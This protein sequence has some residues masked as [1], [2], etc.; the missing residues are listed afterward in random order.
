M[1]MM[2]TCH[3]DTVLSRSL[4]WHQPHFKDTEAQSHLC[5]PKDSKATP[6]HES[7]IKI[8]LPPSELT[9]QQFGFHVENSLRLKSSKQR[10]RE[11]KRWT[12]RHHRRWHGQRPS[13][14][15]AQ[16][17]AQPDNLYHQ[18][19]P[20]SCCCRHKAECR[21]AWAAVD[22]G[23]K[24]SPVNPDPPPKL[25]GPGK[26]EL[27][28]PQPGATN[29]RVLSPKL[30]LRGWVRLVCW[31]FF[32]LNLCCVGPNSVWTSSLNEKRVMNILKT[33]LGHHPAMHVR[34]CFGFRPFP[35]PLLILLMCLIICR[36]VNVQV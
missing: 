8:S 14:A 30:S 26:V 29:R 28:P 17:L 19:K 10:L 2:M 20:V 5:H 36:Y 7:N 22:A 3:V 13:K 15:L 23:E 33:H 25:N 34:M 1:L 32:L 16:E 31:C 6:S 18:Q 27:P 4:T 12:M 35:I 21:R 24:S 9:S 11:G